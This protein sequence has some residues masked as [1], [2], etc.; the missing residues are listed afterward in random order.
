[1]KILA[2]G[3]RTF[4]DPMLA[5][6]VLAWLFDVSSSPQGLNLL[7]HGAADGADSTAA[8]VC[9]DM[10][11]NTRAFPADWDTHGKSAGVKRN[12]EMIEEK[13]DLVV[14]FWD[15]KSRGTR[16]TIGLAFNAKIPTYIHYF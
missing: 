15:G 6:H 11:I 10:G 2:C 5:Q 7:I 13:P 4:D 9:E 3:S 12:V 8:R 14:A 1:M 16:H